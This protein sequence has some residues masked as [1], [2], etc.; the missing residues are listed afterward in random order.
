MPKL[1]QISETYF[2]PNQY[3]LID[4]VK[5]SSVNIR[6]PEEGFDESIAFNTF[7]GDYFRS[8]IDGYLELTKIN[9]RTPSIPINHQEL[10]TK[11]Q[12]AALKEVFISSQL[13]LLG[14]A[15]A[16]GTGYEVA[17]NG[18]D[19][20]EVVYG[21]ELGQRIIRRRAQREIGSL[22]IANYCLRTRYNTITDDEAPWDKALQAHSTNPRLEAPVEIDVAEGDML[23][24]ME[25]RSLSAFANVV[26]PIRISR[27]NTINAFRMIRFSRRFMRDMRRQ[28]NFGSLEHLDS[29][30]DTITAQ[31]YPEFDDNEINAGSRSIHRVKRYLLSAT[32]AVPDIINDPRSRFFLY[33]TDN[34]TSRNIRGETTQYGREVKQYA[35]MQYRAMVR[36]RANGSEA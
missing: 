36:K 24:D 21:Y 19:S 18:E 4:Y 7:G 33:L 32:K 31:A 20:M 1:G 34:L 11:L 23:A 25:S 3:Q 15:A 2:T 9:Q 17:T 29:V 22:L 10:E 27:S 6:F 35:N 5:S 12:V 13:R 8:V 16:M 30:V 28:T 14:K 26:G